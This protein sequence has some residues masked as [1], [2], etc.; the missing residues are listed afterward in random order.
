MLGKTT[1]QFGWKAS[2]TSG[3]GIT[4][5][6]GY[7]HDVRRLERGGVA[8]AADSPPSGLGS[9]ARSASIGHRSIFGHKPSYGPCRCNDIVSTA[10]RTGR[11]RAPSPT[12]R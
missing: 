12:P 11:W 1:R 3:D 9:V 6:R 5:N 10:P 2:A 4:R 7:R 8:A